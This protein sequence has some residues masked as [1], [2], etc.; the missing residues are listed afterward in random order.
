MASLALMAG[1]MFC[2]VLLFGPVSYLISLFRWM[3][4]FIIYS[5]GLLSI[6]IGVWWMLLPIPAIKYYGL[7]DIFLGYKIMADRM[8]KQ[9]QA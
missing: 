3:P 6:I 8:G 9:T 7:I 4:N 2:V 1:L 5:L